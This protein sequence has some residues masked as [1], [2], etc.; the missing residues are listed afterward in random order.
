MTRWN[1][2]NI[3]FVSLIDNWPQSLFCCNVCF[4]NSKMTEISA[5]L[6][7]YLLQLRRW[8]IFHSHPQQLVTK[9]PMDEANGT[10]R[11]KEEKTCENCRDDGESGSQGHLQ[12]GR[13]VEVIVDTCCN[14]PWF[15]SISISGW[16]VT[17]AGGGRR[18]SGPCV[19][20]LVWVRMLSCDWSGPTPSSA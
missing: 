2:I 20:A 10:A 14:F 13:L 3:F 18:L 15:S 8:S 6:C 16:V 1:K 7:W 17:R 12:E 4:Y 19:P 11:A 9:W 5:Y